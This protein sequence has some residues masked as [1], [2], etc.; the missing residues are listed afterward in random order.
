MI[1]K[2]AIFFN[3]WKLEAKPFKNGSNTF[4]LHLMTGWPVQVVKN[5]GTLICKG[6]VQGSSPHNLAPFI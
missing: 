2:I 3:F 6:K 1:K 4:F 5:H